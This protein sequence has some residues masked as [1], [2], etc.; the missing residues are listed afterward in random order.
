MKTHRNYLIAALLTSALTGAAAIAISIATGPDANAGAQTSA[1]PSTVVPQDSSVKEKLTDNSFVEKAALSNMKELELSKLA[2]EKSQNQ[3][4][5]KFAQTI[6]KNSSAAIAQLKTVAAPYR[7]E[8]PQQLN[9][10]HRQMVTE[11][12]QL[13]G[14]KFDETYADL[15]KKGEDTTVGLFDNAAGEATLNAELRVFAHNQLPVLRQNQK[16]A[17]ALITTSQPAAS[18]TPAHKK[19]NGVDS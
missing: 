17:H 11:M 4:V 2:L 14:A 5:K 13:S 8:V 6:V 18:A 16:L 15:M 19:T 9:A 7:L 10:E 12:Q 3:K 1:T